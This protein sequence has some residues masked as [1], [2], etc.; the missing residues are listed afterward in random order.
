MNKPIVPESTVLQAGLSPSFQ[1]SETAGNELR[2]WQ[3]A[4][5]YEVAVISFKDS[6]GD[7]KGEL[8]GLFDKIDYL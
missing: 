3:R 5:I 7:G 1:V 4:A 2:W 6:N 8:K